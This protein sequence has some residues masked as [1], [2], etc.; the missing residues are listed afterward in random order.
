MFKG[1][2]ARSRAGFFFVFLVIACAGSSTW[3]NTPADEG[4]VGSY[5]DA[6]ILTNIIH[7][8]RFE[9]GAPEIYPRIEF[10][11]D[12]VLLFDQPGQSREAFVRVFDA[13]GDLVPEPDLVWESSV[14][15]LVGVSQLAPGSAIVESIGSWSGTLPVTVSHAATGVSAQ[16]AA[17]M[18]QPQAQTHFVPSSWVQAIL[19]DR[20]GIHDATLHRNP[21]TEIIQAGD[22]VVS[23]NQA[24]LMVHVLSVEVTAGY[25]DMTV[26]PASYAEAFKELDLQAQAEPL[27]VTARFDDQRAT[28]T[29]V[30]LRDGVELNRTDLKPLS[31]SDAVSCA[32]ELEN[33]PVSGNVSMDGV[34]LIL[35]L[36]PDASILVEDSQLVMMETK[37]V[38]SV[39]VA[40]GEIQVNLDSSLSFAGSCE[41][42]IPT[43]R[44]PIPLQA[45]LITPYIESA[46]G[47]SIEAIGGASMG[48]VPITGL[49]RSWNLTAGFR[50]TPEGGLSGF[51]EHEAVSSNPSMDFGVDAGVSLETQA[52]AHV[53]NGI[54]F[55]FALPGFNNLFTLGDFVTLQGGPYW[56]FSLSSPLNPALSGYQGPNTEIGVSATSNLGI[57]ASLFEGPLGEY[58]GIGASEGISMPIFD[59]NLV[60]VGTPLPG[61]DVTCPSGCG[62]L[63]AGTGQLDLTMTAD[64]SGDGSG[65]F[66]LSR[67]G[68]SQLTQLATTQLFEGTGSASVT[69]PPD[70]QPGTYQVYPRLCLDSVIYSWFC[71]VFPIASTDPIGSFTVIDQGSLGEITVKIND[72]DD[73]PAEG[74]IIVGA[75]LNG[76]D[77]LPLMETD[78]SGMVSFQNMPTGE[79]HF[80]AYFEGANPFDQL[81]ELWA[82]RVIDVESGANPD[83]ELIRDYPYADYFEI[84]RASNNVI[85]EPG[86]T[87]SPGTQLRVRARLQNQQ[88]VAHMVRVRMRVDRTDSAG[89]DFDEVSNWT[90]L[91]AGSSQYHEVS[92]TPSSEGSYQKALLVEHAGWGK[93][94]AWDWSAAFSVQE[95][96][97]EMTVTVLD[98]NDNPKS[99][100]LV[101]GAGLDGLNDLPTKETNGSGQVTFSGIPLGSYHFQAYFEGQNPFDDGGEL[102]AE[103][104]AEIH[105]GENDALSL[106][107]NYPFAN[108]FEIRR[109]SDNSVVSPGETIL[110]GTQLRVRA[111]VQNDQSTSQTARVRMRLDRRGITGMDFDQFSAWGTIPAGSTSYFEVSFTP[112]STG[113]YEKALWVEHSAWGKTDAWDWSTAFAVEEPAG[114]ITV[115]VRDQNNNVRSNAL[116]VGAGLDGLDDLPT[117]ETNSSG[118]VNFEDIPVGSYHFQAY[119]EG[120]NP[121][122]NGGELWAERI[123][124]IENGANP[125][126]TLKRDYPF[127]NYFEIRRQSDNTVV[128]PGATIEA[129]TELRVRARIQ[130]DR[131]TSETV[132]VRMR[133]DRT[134]ASGT[135]FDQFSNWNTISANSTRY[136]EVNFT[137]EDS[138]DY[139]KALWV[140]HSGWGKTDA[141]DWS[142]AFSVAPPPDDAEITSF[143]PTTGVIYP[144]EEV[145]AHVTIENTGGS[146]RAFW[147]GVSYQRPNGSWLDLPVETAYVSVGDS[148]TITLSETLGPGCVSNGHLGSHSAVAAVWDRH[149]DQSGAV[150]FDDQNDSAYILQHGSVEITN[151]PDQSVVPWKPTISG[152]SFGVDE[153]RVEV[154]TDTWYHQFDDYTSTSGFWSGEATIG[155]SGDTGFSALVKAYSV[156]CPSYSDQI[157]VYR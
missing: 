86:E 153:V 61:G 140:E 144:G 6:P 38:G 77:D 109:A 30:S 33:D 1:R 12:Q 131:S 89:T 7:V 80:Q 84:R 91:P 51:R 20:G 54:E 43:V 59:E 66:W 136:F 81:G 5:R 46:V 97:G 78:E 132:R 94:D 39:G 110:K 16:A 125:E 4:D 8:S 21:E 157:T 108:Y 73:Q 141:W 145:N 76:L 69:V 117:Q 60:L 75:G 95:P 9:E 49:E 25:V 44:F 58:F 45:I 10:L 34:E 62:S 146:D 123:I 154:E 148:E 42:E 37:M 150:R 130:N 139:D 106:A 26:E 112:N 149:P 90:A 23:G 147:I 52:Y 48:W 135:D 63:V 85:V 151:P 119:H 121:F 79:Y 133:V 67:D 124:E 18:A 41:L 155:G 138:G 100:A 55:G 35:E 118:Q 156:D 3:G 31:L 27:R 17:V 152:S 98:Q 74:V 105:E 53:S 88:D 50:Y 102:W 11:S 22:I 129:G 116:V 47:L 107:R 103:E 24:G 68:Q 93:T 19:G 14:P 32:G 72:L 64:T 56:S 36:A 142:E 111:R 28:L 29:T 122:D 134:G 115:V 71:N 83:L 143:Y 87:V 114:D 70:T 137:P 92:F 13:K 57:T 99:G 128:A 82:E 127:A 126:L 104:I 2:K 40:M 15:D 120:D 113:N 101:V 96:V 65:A